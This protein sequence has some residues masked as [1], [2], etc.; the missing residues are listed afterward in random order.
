MSEHALAERPYRGRP[1]T[2]SLLRGRA[3]ACPTCEAPAEKPC[4]SSSG[5]ITQ[6][7]HIARRELTRCD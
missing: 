1:R 4:R 5:K 2:A 3:V 7:I 6:E